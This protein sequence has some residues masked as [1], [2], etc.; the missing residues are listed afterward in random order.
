MTLVHRKSQV[1]K[2]NMFK[3]CKVLPVFLTLYEDAD[4]RVTSYVYFGYIKE[5]EM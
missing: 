4:G 2:Q 3:L 5:N 1:I